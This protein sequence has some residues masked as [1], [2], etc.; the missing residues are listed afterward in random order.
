M[1]VETAGNA[2]NDMLMVF[3]VILGLYWMHRGRFTLAIL[4]L[5]VGT[6][7][8]FIPVL[9]V[10]VVVVEAMKRLENW[11]ARIR[12]LAVTGVAGLLMAALAYAPF[13]DGGDI[14]GVGRRSE[15]FSTS[16]STLVVGT[17]EWLLDYKIAARLVT[18]VAF[19]ILVLWMAYRLRTQWRERDEL[20]PMR[21]SLLILLF[22]LLVCAPWFFQW[23]LV[24]PLAIAA[25]LPPGTAVWG[26]VLFALVASWK[27][28]FYYLFF[29][30]PGGEPGS[31]A[32][33][34]EWPVT[35][36]IIAPPALYL[37][38]SWLRRRAGAPRAA[39]MIGS[40]EK[41]SARTRAAVGSP[42]PRE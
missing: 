5:G 37:A 12:F 15:M 27:P 9:L 17:L 6:L 31:A 19:A 32:I 39:E 25:L 10:P 4:A 38:R 8:K 22:Y 34:P 41:T 35:L 20:S 14:I 23:Y 30:A 16:V 1:I 42:W 36:L 26:T 13:W 21:S 29:L 3:L 7:V 18:A 40:T 33:W 28:A 11:T 2:H 24:W